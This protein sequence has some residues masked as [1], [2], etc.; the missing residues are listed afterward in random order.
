MNDVT[1]Q[2]TPPAAGAP[3]AGSPPPAA[4]GT[5]DAGQPPAPT[6]PE[7]LPEQFWDGETNA[8]KPEFGAHY[9]EIANFHR[10]ETERLA[11][12]NARKPED[13]KLELKLPE[14]LKV[15]DGI[16]VKIDEND[17]RVPL[18]RAIAVK[19]GLTQDAV[20]ELVA[21]DAQIKI[22]AHNAEAA[23]IVSEDAKLGANGKARKDAIGN[24]LKGALERNEITAEEHKDASEL[25]TYASTVTL[26]EKLIAKANGVVPGNGGGNPPAQ[27]A[28][29]QVPITQRW[30]GATTP[31]R[32]VS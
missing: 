32:K 28:Q 13:I 22:E 17:P 9:T 8:V 24:W 25:M 1:N 30:Y 29:D 31:Q 5:P 26:F 16:E 10:T 12:L 21:L 6:R 19:N 3:P 15:P 27:P 23:R 14:G 2:G 20:N 7:Y 11:A 4:G 18:I